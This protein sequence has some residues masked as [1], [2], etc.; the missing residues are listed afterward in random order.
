M[1]KF[2]KIIIG[3]AAISMMA[4]S[5]ARINAGYEG[6]KV[7]LYGDKKGVDDVTLVTG[8]V[9]FNPITTAVYEYPTFIQ[10][11]NYPAFTVNS[12]DGSMFTINPSALIKIKDG[13]TSAI[14][15][16]YRKD[17]KDIIKNTIYIFIMD[18]ARIEF[19][20]YNADEIVSM[21]NIVDKSFEDRVRIALESEGFE[22]QQLT[23]GIGYPKSYE[24]AIDAK[25]KAI[26][27]RLQVENE[28]AVAKAEADKLIVQARAEKEAN[29]LRTSALTPQILEQM[30]IEKWDGHLP[31]YGQVPTLFKDITK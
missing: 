21:R 7:N 19:N 28:V 17:I 15:K 2:L 31:Q 27:Q 26:Q 18:A 23:P 4:V 8:M 16:K 25:N 13:K 14:F 10:T 12:K 22:L 5:C 6:I 1:S 24:D 30:W 20:N 3:I 29:T 9:W 11:I